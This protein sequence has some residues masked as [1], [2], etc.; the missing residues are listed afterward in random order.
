MRKPNPLLKV[1]VLSSSILLF[2][3]CVA[4]HG[5]A[6]QSLLGTGAPPGDGA[7]MVEPELWSGSKSIQ[8]KGVTLGLTPAGEFVPQETDQP[9]TAASTST[10]PKTP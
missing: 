1:A 6:F 4:Y 8:N 5:G 9:P 2:G 3:G 10:Q 7:R